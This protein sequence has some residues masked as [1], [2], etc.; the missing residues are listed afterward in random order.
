MNYVTMPLNQELPIFLE[1]DQFG[2]IMIKEVEQKQGEVWI[3]YEGEGVSES[4][5]SWVVLEE[6]GSNAP[7][8]RINTYEKTAEGYI[9]KFKTSLPLESLIVSTAKR[10]ITKLEGLELEVEIDN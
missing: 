5:R 7:I 2:G 10:N 9:A 8:E 1:Q 4:F 3:Y 6:K